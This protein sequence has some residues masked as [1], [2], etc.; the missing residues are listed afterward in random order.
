M[1][2]EVFIFQNQEYTILVGQSREENAE[3]VNT[4]D[5]ENVWFHVANSPSSHVILKTTCK[6][7]EIPLQVIK[8]C[9]CLCKSHSKSKSTPKCD[10]IYTQIENV[11]STRIIGQ[12]NTDSSKLKFIKI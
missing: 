11:E 10:I 6:I 4:S 2:E 7:K 12:V 1:K 5:P 9:A 8:R 3:L